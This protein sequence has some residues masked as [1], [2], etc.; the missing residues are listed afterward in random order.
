[1]SPRTATILGAHSIPIIREVRAQSS[2]KGSNMK[3]EVCD[4]EMKIVT[5]GEP[6]WHCGNCGFLYLNSTVRDGRL[7]SLVSYVQLLVANY[8][9]P[10]EEGSKQG[11]ILV[12]NFGILMKQLEEITTTQGGEP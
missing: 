10:R 5:P 1:M 4:S 9:T 6:K 7:P 8:N 2:V 11:R 12:K 3:C